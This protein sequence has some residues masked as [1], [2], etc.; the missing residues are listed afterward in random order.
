[1]FNFMYKMYNTQLFIGLNLINN[2]IIGKNN[3]ILTF[4]YPGTFVTI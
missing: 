1:M 4:Y 2:K 3:K